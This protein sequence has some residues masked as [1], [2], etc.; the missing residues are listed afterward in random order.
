MLLNI[1]C[2][3]ELW[4]LFHY[5][6]PNSYNDSNLAQSNWHSYVAVNQAFADA[7]VQVYRP[8]DLIQ[9]SLLMH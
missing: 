7:V 1:D 9:L 4:P 3:T 8:G 6:P 5:L 2:L